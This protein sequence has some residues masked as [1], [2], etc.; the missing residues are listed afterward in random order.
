[1]TAVSGRPYT[2]FGNLDG[3]VATS[4]PESINE[5]RLPWQLTTNLQFDKNFRLNIGGEEA[6]SKYLNFNVY[7]RITNLLDSDN[8]V[9]V[10]QVSQSADDSGWLL[11]DGGQTV[12]N[13]NIRN[14]FTAENYE[15]VYDWRILAPNNYARPRQIF[16]GAI[17]NF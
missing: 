8:I 3:P 5:T 17:I 9:D 10:Y 12:I 1:L 11:S 7:L 16:L 13:N 14:G 15:S 2:V 6:S 4:I